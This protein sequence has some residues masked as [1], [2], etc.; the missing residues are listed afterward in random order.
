MIAFCVILLA[1]VL[2]F[3]ICEMLKKKSKMQ[4]HNEME[5]VLNTSNSMTFMANDDRCYVYCT[6]KQVV[7]FINAKILSVK[8]EVHRLKLRAYLIGF[9]FHKSSLFI[10]PH[11]FER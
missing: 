5:T 2:H 10:Q 1:R 4:L 11:S 8:Y 7:N 6:V 3:I 9:L